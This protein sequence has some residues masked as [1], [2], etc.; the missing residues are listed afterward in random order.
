MNQGARSKGKAKASLETD[1]AR[2]RTTKNFT[3][4]LQ[5]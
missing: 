5:N 3:S 4:K 2:P 1:L